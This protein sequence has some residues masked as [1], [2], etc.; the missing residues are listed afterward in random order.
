[1]GVNIISGLSNIPYHKQYRTG[2]YKLRPVKKRNKRMSYIIWS[3]SCK[4]CKGQ[5]YLEESEDGPYLTC[6]QCGYS[7]KIVDPDALALLKSIQP[8]K[9]KLLTGV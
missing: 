7:E 8:A 1:L 5:F 3:R 9:K 4:K 6:I 2:F